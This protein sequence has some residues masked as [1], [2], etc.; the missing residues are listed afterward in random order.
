[1]PAV[2]GKLEHKL[3]IYLHR[4]ALHCIY[5]EVF[6][7]KRNKKAFYA[8]GINAKKREMFWK[9]KSHTSNFDSL[10][11]CS[12]KE[13]SIFKQLM[14]M[15]SYFLPLS[16]PISILE[17]GLNSRQSFSCRTN[18]LVWSKKS[19]GDVWHL[20]IASRYRSENRGQK[21]INKNY[22]EPNPKVNT[23]KTWC[24]EVLQILSSSICTSAARD[25]CQDPC[26]QI[27]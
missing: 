14:K 5:R 12:Y 7:S 27:V 2:S 4:P 8:I 22:S 15:S 26:F 11:Q 24:V 3:A 19:C 6:M 13:Q 21:K 17:K 20:L 16:I 23:H 9:W 25:I 10:Q 1:M 18:L